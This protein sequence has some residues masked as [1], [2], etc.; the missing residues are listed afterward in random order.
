[1]AMAQVRDVAAHAGVSPATVSNALNH[2]EKVSPVT[3]ARVLTAIKELGYVRNDAARQLRQRGNRAVGMIVLDVANP[4]FAGVAQ[5]AEL[6]LAGTQR[7]LLLGNSA[8]QKER[9][10][11]YLNLFEEQRVSGIL[12]SPVGNVMNRLRQLRKRGT[13]VVIVDRKSGERE[14]SSVSTDDIHGG[15]LAAEHLVARGRRRL[16]VI[17]GP[18]TIRQVADRLSGA[19][20]VAERR[21]G[22]TVEY[23]DTGAM[24]V[25]SG[26]RGA[27]ALMSRPAHQRPDAIFAANDLVALGALQE[28]VRSG[29]SVPDDIALMGYDDIVF[30]VS[31]AIPLTSVRQPAVE[32]GSCAAD[33]LL[34]AI[35]DP[36]V[37]AEH[38][39]FTPTLVARE[40]TGMESEPAST[41]S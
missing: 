31:A 16:A 26:R 6:S 21:E 23:L 27:H 39:M 37:H 32:I 12:I 18:G 3:R 38:P 15:Q 5:G 14:F 24:D 25:E 2:P 7:P 22:V 17:G 30:A 20:M 40:S 19:R 4:F 29:I 28:L 10:L 8:Q 1:M 35:D 34:A 11:S 36:K 41:P 13:A 9:E 33:L